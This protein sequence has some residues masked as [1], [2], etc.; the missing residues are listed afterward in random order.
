MEK[1]LGDTRFWFSLLG[2]FVGATYM[3]IETWHKFL[4]FPASVIFYLVLATILA[5]KHEAQ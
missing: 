4:V 5:A 3:S 2:Y 1:Y